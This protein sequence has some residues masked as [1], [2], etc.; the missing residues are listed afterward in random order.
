VAHILEEGLEN[1]T[2][3]LVDETGDTLDTTTTSETAN[4]RLG[5][6]LDVVT[7]D[8]ALKRP[9][10]SKSTSRK[11]RPAGTNVH[12]ASHHPFRDLFHLFH[13]QTCFQ[14][15]KDLWRVFWLRGKGRA[16]S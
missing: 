12:D 16:M 5:D 3:L 1:T 4:G 9:S 7:E 8:L 10:A 11:E 6:A 15:F 2:S 13:V 14:I